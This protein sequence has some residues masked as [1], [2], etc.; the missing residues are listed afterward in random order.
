M[1][2]ARLVAV[3]AIAVVK[4]KSG[5][6]NSVVRNIWFNEATWL[7]KRESRD[8]TP[9]RLNRGQSEDPKFPTTIRA[10]AFKVHHSEGKNYA[11][12]HTPP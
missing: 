6:R 12:V 9:A 2:L 3:A 5:F 10:I 1:H 11:C 4:V 8:Y 7:V